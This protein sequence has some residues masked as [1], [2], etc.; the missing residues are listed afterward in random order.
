MKAQIALQ[1]SEQKFRTLAEQSPNMI[2]INKNGRVVYVNP[3]CEELLGYSTDEFLA[4]DFDFLSLIAPEYYDLIEEN[5]A[6]HLRGEDVPSEEYAL[7][8]KTG[9]RIEYILTTRL[10]PY[11]NEPALL[12]FVTDITHR[13]KLERELKADF[14]TLEQKVNERT[15][16]LS[17]SQSQVDV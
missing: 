7:F 15:A 3:R 11:E 10:I 5:M 2:F 12:G 1:E 9:K 13:K 16:E 4:Q 14:D 6:K 17:D 8:T